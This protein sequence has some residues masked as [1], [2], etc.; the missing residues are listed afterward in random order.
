[1]IFILQKLIGQYL[2][3]APYAPTSEKS[4]L[5][6]MTTKIYVGLF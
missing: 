4:V 3:T 6:A 2:N 5:A 1:M